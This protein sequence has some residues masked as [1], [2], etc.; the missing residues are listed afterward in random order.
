[1]REFYVTH[2]V[3]SAQVQPCQI[4]DALTNQGARDG[5]MK[6]ST[7]PDQA[8][9]DKHWRAVEASSVPKTSNFRPGA[10][11]RETPAFAHGPDLSRKELFSGHANRRF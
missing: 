8:Q 10:G 4:P 2:G 6:R 11:A 5:D 1:M 9:V 7:K 3:V